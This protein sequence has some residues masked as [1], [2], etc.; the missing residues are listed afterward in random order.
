MLLKKTKNNEKQN[1]TKQQQQQQTNKQKIKEIDTDFCHWEPSGRSGAVTM[2]LCPGWLPWEDL[3]PQWKS[4]RQKKSAGP[5]FLSRHF[6][7]CPR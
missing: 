4:W 5:W 2:A 1:Q 3:N 7:Y 6:W